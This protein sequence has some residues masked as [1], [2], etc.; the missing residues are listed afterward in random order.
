VRGF[1]LFK[2]SFIM[3]ALAL[4]A[5]LVS[6]AA[7]AVTVDTFDFALSTGWTRPIPG[8]VPVADPGG[9][10]VGSFVGVVEP[11]ALGTIA[12]GDLTAFSASFTDSEGF[13]I[14]GSILQSGL[15]T[16]SSFRYETLGGAGTLSFGQML[17]AEK[18]SA[19]VGFF[20]F[21]SDATCSFRAPLFP[22]ANAFIQGAQVPYAST[23]DLPTVTLVSSVTTPPAVPEPGTWVLFG[24]GAVGIAFIGRRKDKLALIE[25]D[26]PLR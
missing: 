23:A 18:G 22:G 5:I 15:G 9:S 25:R 17:A 21:L 26:S 1:I 2:N 6:S 3:G 14:G 11:D 7:S 24:L 19:C 16:F 20:A 10:L 13:A 4:G 8:G 12:L